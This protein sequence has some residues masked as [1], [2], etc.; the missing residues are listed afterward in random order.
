MQIVQGTLF[1]SSDLILFQGCLQRFSCNL[2]IG[3]ISF[4]KQMR[5]FSSSS[6]WIWEFPWKEMHV[7]VTT[8]DFFQK[9]SQPKSC[10]CPL[11]KKTIT[12][13]QN[14]GFYA[15][16]HSYY[17]M[18][19]LRGLGGGKANADFTFS[20]PRTG[21][22]REQR[23]ARTSP[24]TECPCSSIFQKCRIS[25]LLDLN[26]QLIRSLVDSIHVKAWEVL[27]MLVFRRHYF[28]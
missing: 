28:T 14:K 21:K 26:L 10:A 18:S 15:G 23:P 16:M 12:Q 5:F 8:S 3:R 27:T 11:T 17:F 24:P 19:F 13:R 9:P 2:I 20:S 6:I 25:G 1:Y 22:H 4:P 7:I